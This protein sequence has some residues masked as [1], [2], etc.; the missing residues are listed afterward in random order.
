MRTPKPKPK[1]SF[2]TQL[3]GLAVAGAFVV[4]SI[5]AIG[6]LVFVSP[7]SAAVET[8]VNTHALRPQPTPR[9]TIPMLESYPSA[10][11]VELVERTHEIT[12]PEAQDFT[13]QYEPLVRARLAQVQQNAQNPAKRE[14]NQSALSASDGH[15]WVQISSGR[16]E[17]DAYK[18]RDALREQGYP[19]EVHQDGSRFPVRIG[20]YATRDDA[21]AVQAKFKGSVLR[22]LSP[23]KAKGGQ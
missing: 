19:A 17:A 23:K 20:G 11:P 14:T 21:K 16:N 9:Q 13:T 8:P 3:L 10:A 4:V 6:R 22:D 7:E 1:S 15:F 2:F 5:G 18:Q 12:L